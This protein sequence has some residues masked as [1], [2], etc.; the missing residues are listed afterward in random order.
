MMKKVM[1]GAVMVLGLSQ[2]ASAQTEYSNWLYS[3]SI[4][5]L[6]TPAGTNLA[7]KAH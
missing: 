7:A 4:H 2:T 1:A 6:S 3:G 5:I